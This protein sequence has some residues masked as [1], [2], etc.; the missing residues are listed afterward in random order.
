[1]IIF[2]LFGVFTFV[3]VGVLFVDFINL[4]RKYAPF[5]PSKNEDFNNIDRF[6]EKHKE[7][8][9]A[10][11]GS[12][13]GRVLMYLASKTNSELTGYEINP[14]VSLLAK[15]RINLANLQHRINIYNKNFL[16]SD[17]SQYDLFYIYGIDKIM[18]QVEEKL[19]NEAQEGTYIVSNK[20]RF[21]N[22]NHIVTSNNLHLYRI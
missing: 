19:M 20:F 16:G 12:G 8:K 21:E 4:I 13:D 2:I 17:F 5:L 1:M 15:I 22:L 9:I 10:D 6:L 11:L 14:F 18:P 3:F 7:Y